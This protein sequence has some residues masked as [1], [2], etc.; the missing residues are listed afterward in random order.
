[1]FV[2]SNILFVETFCFHKYVVCIYTKFCLSV[3]VVKKVTF[4]LDIEVIPV[5]EYDQIE[6]S[7]ENNRAPL[8]TSF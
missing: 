1:M 7:E 5:P 8:E 4:C 6:M 3:F 2:S